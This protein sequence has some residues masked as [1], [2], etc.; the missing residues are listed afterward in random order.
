MSKAQK[1]NKEKNGRRTRT[2]LRPMCPPT[3]RH[4]ARVSRPS[5]RSRERPE[6]RFGGKVEGGR[7]AAKPAI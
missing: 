1:G 6:A 3:S 4:K 7:F 5:T 2:S